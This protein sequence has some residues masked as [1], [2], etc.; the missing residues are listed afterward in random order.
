MRAYLLTRPQFVFVAELGR[1]VDF[2]DADRRDLAVNIG[3]SVL[4]Q[5]P[6]SF[7]RLYGAYSLPSKLDGI[8]AR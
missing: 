7:S 2:A 3:P 6:V 1:L 8:G 4:F 5:R